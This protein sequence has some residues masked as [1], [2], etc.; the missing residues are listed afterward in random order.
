MRLKRTGCFW[1]LL[2]LTAFARGL[3]AQQTPDSQSRLE[4]L[5]SQSAPTLLI[6]S[7]TIVTPSGPGGFSRERLNLSDAIIVSVDL[8]KLDRKKELEDRRQILY[9]FALCV[10]G[11]K[12]PSSR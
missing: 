10:A 4:L 5:T 9:P 2:A 6:R 7:R 12:V 1:A 3:L 8:E 11:P